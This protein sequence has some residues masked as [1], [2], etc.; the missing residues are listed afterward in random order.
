MPNRFQHLCSEWI[1]IS[2]DLASVA[3]VP[4]VLAILLLCSSIELA[5]QLADAHVIG[6]RLWRGLAY[7]NG[8]FWEGLLHNWRP[9]YQGQPALMFLTYAFFHADFWHL[10]G[11]M[12]ALLILARIV[13]AQ[14]GQGGFVLIYVFSAV[15]GAFCFA[16]LSQ[17]AA[18]MVGASGALFGLAGA[19]QYW[20]WRDLRTGGLSLFPV[21]RALVALMLLNAGLWV[22]NDGALAWQT[23]LGGFLCGW[24]FASF[25][26][27]FGCK[28]GYGGNNGR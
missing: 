19:W 26:P 18:P 13:L 1:S 20:E 15:G 2:R 6:T 21:W 3:R 10:S 12:L 11:N 7:Q 14:V 23:H 22:M 17:T 9:N 27:A 24:G 25:L 5:L 16:L 28:G 4:V 8:A